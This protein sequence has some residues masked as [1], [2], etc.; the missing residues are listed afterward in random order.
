MNLKEITFT[1]VGQVRNSDNCCM[2][3][4]ADPENVKILAFGNRK[5]AFKIKNQEI[6][7]PPMRFNGNFEIQTINEEP[8]KEENDNYSDRY[9]KVRAIPLNKIH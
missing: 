7:L 3:K 6:T 8:K 1:N 2:K 5:V 4:R 9:M